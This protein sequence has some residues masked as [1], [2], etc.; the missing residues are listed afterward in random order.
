MCASEA[1]RTGEFH[2][3]MQLGKGAPNAGGEMRL[4]RH[5]S[6]TEGHSSSRGTHLDQYPAGLQ[7]A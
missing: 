2:D 1:A 7:G 4:L 5:V 3:L 6:E